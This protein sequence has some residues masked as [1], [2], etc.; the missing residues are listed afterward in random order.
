[1][2][3]SITM[4]AA[5]ILIFVH[6]L[7]VAP[8]EAE[9]V[10]FVDTNGT[11]FEL[12]DSPYYYVGTNFWYGLNLA[13][14]GPG[15]DRARLHQELN[16]L[17]ELRITNLRIMAGSEGP[18]TEPWR[19]VPALQVSAGVYDPNVLDGLDYLLKA[20]GERDIRAVMCLNNF[21]P[22]SG[23]MAQ[24]LNWNGAGAIP[25]PP[26]EPGGDWD[27]YAFYTDDFYSNAGAMQDFN[28]FINLIINRVNPH[29]GIA[30]K[31]DPT[32]IAWE[33][34]NEPRGYTRVHQRRELQRLD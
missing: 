33:L 24:Y 1:M 10:G 12:N 14:T 7:G 32:I 11:H 3:Q 30:Y 8:V 17:K 2:K 26:P 13:S 34:A 20:M 23:G 22:W 25:Y 28:D 9:N 6:V 5:I 21:W 27:E 4:G 29:T 18:N 19:M 16:L 15:G 31:D